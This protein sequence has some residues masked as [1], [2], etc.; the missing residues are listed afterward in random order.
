MT[1]LPSC[2]RRTGLPVLR[3]ITSAWLTECESRFGFEL[4]GSWSAVLPPR[5]SGAMRARN[6]L[7]PDPRVV[8]GAVG[9]SD[10]RAVA[11][12]WL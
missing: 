8:R 9:R 2:G 4:S 11:M 6:W 3:A 10:E 5:Q 1:P 12:S 7:S